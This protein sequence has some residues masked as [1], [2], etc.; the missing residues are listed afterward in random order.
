[1]PHNRISRFCDALM[2]ACWLMA[3]IVAPLF[4]NIYS[5]RVFEPDKIALVRSLALLAL[6]AWLVKL[7]ADGGPRFEH[8]PALNVRS[9]LRVPLLAP[10]TALAIMYVIATMLSVAPNI[11]LYGSYQR[12]Q[13]AFST[14]SYLVLF[15]VVAANLRRR[16]QIERI[17]TVVV[18]TSL[19][20]S[21]YGIL[22]RYAQDPLPWGGD[23]VERV[24]GH[25]G[26]AIFIG[27]YLIIS[28][29]AVLGR[30]VTSFRAVMLSED[31]LTA[32]TFRAALYIF[33]LA[34]NLVAIWFTQS[35]GP[36]LGLLAGAF[37]FFVLLALHYRVRWLV[38]TTVA[39]GVI[40]G[41]FIIVLNIPNGPLTGLAEVR[42]V[43]RLAKVLD[44]IQ[45]NTGTGRVR[46]LIWTGVVQMMTPHEPIQNP[47]GSLDPW[48][49]IRPLVG[50]GPE[51]MLVAYNR[52]Y[53]PELGQLEARNASPDRSHNETFDAL[54]FTGVLGLLAQ[55]SLFVAIF[56]FSLKW[57][58]LID[59]AARRNVFLGLVIGGGALSTVIFVAWQGPQFFGVSLPLGM[60]LGLIAFLTLYALL[61]SSEESSVRLESW[62]AVIMISLIAAIVAHF[63]EIH[64]G[65]AIVS[66]R[67]H[68][69]IFL[70]AMLV[71][72]WIWPQMGEAQGAA[73]KRAAETAMAEASAS[74]GETLRVSS[75]RTTVSPASRAGKRRSTTTTFNRA[76]NNLFSPIALTAALLWPVFI[77]LGY[78]FLAARNTDALTIIWN[79]LTVLPK[80]EGAQISVGILMLMFLTWVMGAALVYME[81]AP[82]ARPNWITGLFGSLG[83]LALGTLLAWLIHAGAATQFAIA[84]SSIEDVVRVASV[85]TV[86][87][88]LMLMALLVWAAVLQLETPAPLRSRMNTS[89]PAWLGYV[90][91]P[92]VAL[93]AA[94]TL[95]LQVIQADIIYKTGV[96]YDDGGNSPVAIELF[97]RTLQLAPS[98]DFYYLFL[99]RAY[100]NASNTVQ[101]E[102]RDRLFETAE[103]QLQKARGINPLNTDHSANLARLNRQWAILSTDAAQRTT[104]AQKADGH[105]VEALRLSPNN[106]GLWNEWGLLAFQ[107]LEDGAKAQEKLDHSLA[108]DS[109]FDQTYLYLGDLYAW[110]ARRT[111]DAVEQA[112][113]FNKSIMAYQQGLEAGEAYRSTSA[114]GLRLGLANV[115]VTTQQYQPAIDAYLKVAEL[116]AG[117]GQWQ[118]FRALGELYRQTGDM[119][120]A[121]EY[122]QQ[123]LA[124][125]PEANKAEV[126]QW[127]DELK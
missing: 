13:G 103:A 123:A 52:F 40:A 12:M 75:K 4:F 110:E 106:V 62:R 127:L 59:S 67:T 22:Q 119:I 21:I 69:W 25:M 101:P 78:D 20:I 71:L 70:A 50:Y 33:I 3:L 41:A 89:G 28:A 125:A 65:I 51:A 99:G 122:G 2:E 35:R 108:L 29:M 9:W 94:T 30:V 5:S 68:F 120:K 43:N 74:S 58:G 7:I 55:L 14:F 82:V 23:T 84:P 100:L 91:L 37:F 102:E 61:P 34:V 92:I 126:Q 26:N 54:A 42:G 95:N 31:R 112:D 114:L 79:S 57:L 10:V 96:Q 98:Q 80:A 113:I 11:S 121:R 44:E 124:L 76:P 39:L 66:T 90:G 56:Y 104:R 38:L 116:N 107:L 88:A 83:V 64:F 73:V 36:Q 86:Y 32:H 60:V 85:L 81:E 48:N 63:T 77:T 109:T 53:P 17:V 19:P 18:I 87:Y 72:G 111:T 6:A 45:G 93:V 1:M 118:V 115:Y 8:A 97:N 47:D 16:A 24:T 46:V 117:P 105:Y 49:I 15:A 27:A